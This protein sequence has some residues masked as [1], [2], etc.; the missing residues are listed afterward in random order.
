MQS[1]ATDSRQRLFGGENIWS[2]KVGVHLLFLVKFNLVLLEIH[3]VILHH[4]EIGLCKAEITHLLCKKKYPC[5]TDL[6]FV[7]FGFSNFAYAELVTYSLVLLNANYSNGG[8]LYSDTATYKVI[9]CSLPWDYHLNF[10][11]P[12]P[13]YA[14]EECNLLGYD[15]EMKGFPFLLG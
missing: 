14:F 7:F 6:L 4:T 8:Q 9:E 1:C 13:N 3:T 2:V 5:M 11:Y 10:L 12:I 15:N